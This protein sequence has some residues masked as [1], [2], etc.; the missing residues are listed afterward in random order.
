M[1]DAQER[2]GVERE[3]IH[4][5]QSQTG[6]AGQ[7]QPPH[8]V[9]PDGYDHLTLEQMTSAVSAMRPGLVDD[10]YRTWDGISQKLALAFSN[11]T[12]EFER[13]IGGPNGSGAWAGAAASAAV[14]AVGRYRDESM[15][16]AEAAQAIGLK[17]RELRTGLEET[18][19]L[20]PGATEA[21]DV[22]GRVL[23]RNGVMKAGDHDRTE[24]EEEARRILRTVYAQVAG[25]VDAGMPYLPAAPEI[26]AGTGGSV[27]RRRSSEG[28]VEQSQ[29]NCG[30]DPATVDQIV[31][32]P[33][34]TSSPVRNAGPAAVSGSPTPTTPAGFG[35]TSEPT[36][37]ADRGVD[38]GAG[39]FGRSG[40]ADRSRD[41]SE[42]S[43]MRDGASPPA[44]AVR[45]RGSGPPSGA[46]VP[47]G[48]GRSGGASVPGGSGPSSG[49]GM[50][51][52]FG[53]PGGFSHPGG[54]GQ[55]GGSGPSGGLGRSGGAG[56]PVE[57]R[58]SGG[59]SGSGWFGGV[60]E[61]SGAGGS[62]RAGGASGAGRQ[63]GAGGFGGVG[64][65]GGVGGF[66][67]STGAGGSGRSVQ[68]GAPVGNV[69]PSEIGS[70]CVGPVR[71]GVAGAPG[72]GALASKA[73]V[74]D[75]ERKGAPEYLV[76]REHGDEVTG[77][78]SVEQVAPETE[79]GG[80][81][82]QRD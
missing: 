76:T 40:A 66:G 69:P 34:P 35:P 1:T 43:G 22:T 59:S 39:D 13:T 78:R 64:G 25:Q 26:A 38:C 15:P 6:F 67:G 73:V 54:W 72:V 50:S 52:G 65:W 81:G 53:R 18:R 48:S 17:L 80:C 82:Q 47:G 16:L 70:G 14:D 49:S 2:W 62:D 4:Q 21:V 8:I 19:L 30:I 27:V 41:S 56:V 63:G 71:P 12:A 77:L 37:L 58:W 36:A 32:R 10:A 23:P 45:P 46:G 44:G 75:K 57:S 79:G 5:C 29:R 61:S 7:L 33:D 24:A 60:G 3:R 55:L 20:M 74:D 11:F 31:A 51:G 42:P 68:G 28:V 9:S